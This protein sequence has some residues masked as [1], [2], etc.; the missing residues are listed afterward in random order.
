MSELSVNQ[1]LEALLDGNQAQAVAERV[2]TAIIT[3][4]E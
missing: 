2:P 1:L 3:E 4:C